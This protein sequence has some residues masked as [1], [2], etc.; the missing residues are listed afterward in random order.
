MPRGK[1]E[2]TRTK[3]VASRPSDNGGAELEAIMTPA[4]TP[5]DD[6]PPQLDVYLATMLARRL[7]F[8]APDFRPAWEW[9]AEFDEAVGVLLGS[10]DDHAAMVHGADRVVAFT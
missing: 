3:T 7:N 5:L 1:S 2:K 8:G 6:G 10:Q 9:L 4:G